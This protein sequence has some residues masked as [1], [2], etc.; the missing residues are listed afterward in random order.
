MRDDNSDGEEEE[1]AKDFVVWRVA[2]SAD[3]GGRHQGKERST[4]RLGKGGGVGVERAACNAGGQNG[5]GPC[6]GALR[7]GCARREGGGSVAA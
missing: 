6:W 5:W 1:G 7:C 3:C 2:L 4:D